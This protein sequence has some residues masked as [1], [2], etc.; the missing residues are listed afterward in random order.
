ML[1]ADAGAYG[2]VMSNTY[3]QRALPREDVIE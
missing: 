3:N 1:I 2:Y